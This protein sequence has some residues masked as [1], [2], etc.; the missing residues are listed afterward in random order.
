MAING[1]NI[2]IEQGGIGGGGTINVGG[3]ISIDIN[4]II[5]FKDIIPSYKESDCIDQTNIERLKELLLSW[6]FLDVIVSDVSLWKIATQYS[7]GP[8]LEWKGNLYVQSVGLHYLKCKNKDKSSYQGCYDLYSS[9]YILLNTHASGYNNADWK[10]IYISELGFGID[11]KSTYIWDDTND[12][13][14]KFSI[15]NQFV[16]AIGENELSKKEQFTSDI[17]DSYGDTVKYEYLNQIASYHTIPRYYIGNKAKSLKSISFDYNVKTSGTNGQFIFDDSIGY[18]GGSRKDAK[19]WSFYPQ[20]YPIIVFNNMTDVDAH[21]VDINGSIGY[22]DKLNEHSFTYSNG[23]LKIDNTEVVVNDNDEVVFYIRKHGIWQA[24]QPDPAGKWSVTTDTVLE[25]TSETNTATLTFEPIQI[26]KWEPNNT[27]FPFSCDINEISKFITNITPKDYTKQIIQSKNN[28][29]ISL[30]ILSGS[31][32]DNA[33]AKTLF[34]YKSLFV[35]LGDYDFKTNSDGSVSNVNKISDAEFKIN[36]TIKNLQWVSTKDIIP[37]YYQL[38]QT[39][40]VEIE[41]YKVSLR[42]SQNIAEVNTTFYQ[43]FQSLIGFF[44]KEMGYYGD[45][46]NKTEDSGFLDPTIV[47]GTQVNGLQY[48]T[49]YYYNFIPPT[50][51]NSSTGPSNT[52]YDSYRFKLYIGYKQRVQKDTFALAVVVWRNGKSAPS[53]S[54]ESVSE[55]HE[56]YESSG[57]ASGVT[58]TYSVQTNIIAKDL[59]TL[60]VDVSSYEGFSAPTA[61]LNLSEKINGKWKITYSLTWNGGGAPYARVKTR[62]TCKRY[63]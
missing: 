40:N 4:N 2:N 24:A 14:N 46:N 20:T 21:Y 8:R 30:P 57:I 47:S 60:S 37:H 9:G 61:T 48:Y 44:P 51:G 16:T 62:I 35:S 63:M 28:V 39:A 6:G 1:P 13:L 18:K 49:S 5:Y 25:L 34:T 55:L 58:K 54:T 23:K 10:W 53:I 29:N 42:P 27:T 22:Y 31:S 52:Y 45:M 19:Y 41:D 15:P 50:T 3:K 17:I 11:A 38:T 59:D 26:Y 7:N 36:T 12:I 33:H 32:Y 56:I 43:T